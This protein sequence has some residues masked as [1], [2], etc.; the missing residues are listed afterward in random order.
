MFSDIAVIFLGKWL[1]V[2]SPQ[3]PMVGFVSSPNRHLCL[4]A[5]STFGLITEK[6]DETIWDH[7]GPSTWVPDGIP[8]RALYFVLCLT[9]SPNGVQMKRDCSCG[10]QPA[11]Q[12]A[13]QPAS[14]PASHPVS[15]WRAA[16]LFFHH[17]G[18]QSSVGA[19][20][21]STFLKHPLD[22]DPRGPDAY[23]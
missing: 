10:S 3:T 20:I 6:H 18:F 1:G 21:R 23:F 19:L 15:Q 4:I 2:L 11:S 9:L 8:P 7:M 16:C 14:Q 17:G 12:S 13:S 22:Q 5:S